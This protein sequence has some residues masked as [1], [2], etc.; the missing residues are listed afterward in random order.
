[1]RADRS[2]PGAG[3]PHRQPHDPRPYRGQ[4]HAGAGGGDPARTRDPRGRHAAGAAGRPAPRDPRPVPHR[5]QPQRAAARAGDRGQRRRGAGAGRCAPDP[6]RPVRRPDTMSDTDTQHTETAAPGPVELPEIRTADAS[7]WSGP[8]ILWRLPAEWAEALRHIRGDQLQAVGRGVI[9]AT[10]ELIT[11]ERERMAEALPLLDA[12]L[13]ADPNILLR[14]A[15]AARADSVE[16]DGAAAAGDASS[17]PPPP[18]TPSENGSGGEPE[19]LPGRASVGSRDAQVEA[20]ILAQ[21]Q[22]IAV[23]ELPGA[24]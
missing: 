5:H 7:E 11:A 15:R 17:Q 4:R 10:R 12:A 13:E 3:L 19:P 16:G 9:D 8:A 14:F 6:P 20:A 1:G 24:V 21:P 23:R 2:R 18:R 22:G